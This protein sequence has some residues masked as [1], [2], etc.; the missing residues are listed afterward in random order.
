MKIKL[1]A[2]GLCALMV[3]T[4]IN[5]IRAQSRAV[6][7]VVLG[8]GAVV[9]GIILYHLWKLADRIP[10]PERPPTPPPPQ[11]QTGTTNA[12]VKQTAALHVGSSSQFWDIT[13]YST[14]DPKLWDINGQ[15][16]QSYINVATESSENGQSYEK[17]MGFRVWFNQVHGVIVCS[18]GKGRNISTNFF[19][20]ADGWPIIAGPELANSGTRL[21]R[22]VK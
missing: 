8:I 3:A 10:A 17:A 14:S 11:P 16:Y 7:L 2:A 1:I 9:G 22:T 5:Q 15:P 13:A 18:D 19:A 20:L 12:P 6:G 21:F 4:P